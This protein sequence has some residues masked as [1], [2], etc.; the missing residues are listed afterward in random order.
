MPAKLSTRAKYIYLISLYEASRS[1]HYPEWFRSQKDMSALY[2]I[3]DTT[4]SA[5]F[6]ELEQN[7]LIEI[8]RGPLNPDDFSD[9]AANVY[10][11]LP[12]A[13][14]EAE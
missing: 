12:I 7:R 5:G 1:T 3:S 2:G 9:R 13:S 14:D 8:T 10:R 4:I 6:K 11:I